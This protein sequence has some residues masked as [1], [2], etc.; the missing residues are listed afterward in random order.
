MKEPRDE[1]ARGKKLFLESRESRGLIITV[2]MTNMTAGG[3]VGHA[4]RP[5]PGT[6][7]LYNVHYMYIFIS[8]SM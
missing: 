1:G 5:P 2:V 3:L 6:L 7:A 8:W 4:T